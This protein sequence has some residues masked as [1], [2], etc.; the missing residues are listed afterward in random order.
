MMNPGNVASQLMLRFRHTIPNAARLDA[1]CGFPVIYSGRPLIWATENTRGAIFDAMERREVYATTGPR[2]TV[3]FFGGWEFKKEDA[4]RRDL[5]QLGYGKGVPMGAHSITR[6]SSKFRRHV[7]RLM[8]ASNSI[9]SCR[10]E[11]R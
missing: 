4:L 10:Q 8:T 7:G 11:S 2:M 5:A 3:R 1:A 6:A 9:W